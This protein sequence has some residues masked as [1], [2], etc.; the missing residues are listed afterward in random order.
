[1]IING[2]QAEAD[3]KAL[4]ELVRDSEIKVYQETTD[5]PIWALFGGGKDDMFVY[6]K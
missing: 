2:Q 6:D 3:F 4:Q 1:M 5:E